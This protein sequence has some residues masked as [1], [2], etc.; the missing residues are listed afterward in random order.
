MSQFRSRLPHL[1]VRG[2]AEAEEYTSPRQTPR[3]KFPERSRAE[4]ATHL[5]GQIRD[6][7]K[8]NLQKRNALPLGAPAPDGIYLEFEGKAGFDL[9]IESLDL[10]SQGIELLSVK[11]VKDGEE[12][13]TL[14]SV[15]VPNEK[16]S[17]F[18]KKI[19]QYRDEEVKTKSKS[20]K[21]SPKNSP[22]VNSIENV[23]LAV[24]RSLWTDLDEVFPT[25][26]ELIWWEVWLRATPE[27]I[28][29][30]TNFA[31][32]RDIT[33]GSRHLI[34]PDRHV[35]LANATTQ[36]LSLLIDSLGFIAELRRAKETT[37]DFL[38]MPN[39]E[40]RQWVE[41]LKGIVNA[42]DP[43]LSPV[44][45]ILDTG[46]NRQHPLIE[47]FLPPQKLLT[48][49][50]AW[51][52]NDHHG[53]GT[54][55]TGVALYGDLNSALLS[56]VRI[57]IPCEVE[58]VKIV[59][60]TQP[61][62]PDLYGNVTEEAVNRAAVV[63]PNRRRIVC[64][65]ITSTDSRDRGQPSSWSAAVDNICAGTSVR[66][67]RH[68]F[69]ISAGNTDV[70]SRV[71]YPSSNLTDQ[72]HDPGQSWN[73]LTVGAFTE[74]TDITEVDYKGW[75]PL[76]EA[77]DIAPATTTSTTWKKKW[78]HKPDVVFEGGNAAI[79]KNQT[80]VEYP[81]SLLLLTTHGQALGPLFTWTSDT[82]AAA[83]QAA[84]LAAILSSEYP[85]FWAET[86]RALLVHS[87]EWTPRM[88]NAYPL[89]T[90][91]DRENLLRICGYG[92]PNLER[93]R[94]SASNNL[95]LIAQDELRPFDG[96][97]MKH[98]NI[99]NIPWPT[100]ELRAL[101]DTQ[102]R[103]KVTLS[104]FIEPNP[105][106]RGWEHKFRYQSHGLRFD[107]RTPTESAKEF[108]TR[109]NRKRW[110]EEL[111]RKTVTTSGD[112]TDWYFGEHIR[113]RGSIHNDVWEG[114]A[115]SL[116]ERSQLSVF[117]VVGWW[118][119]KHSEGHTTK[120]ARYSLIV[121]ISTPSTE[122]DLYTPVEAKVVTPIE[123]M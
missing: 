82:S 121:S 54:E 102:V 97:S 58:S 22:L 111:G 56:T 105:A 74:K 1:I 30:F 14:A 40:Q 89:K 42:P 2:S 45:C 85:D 6:S 92:V 122:I 64:M 90:K 78:P 83:A 88:K 46:V 93:A 26:D 113:S 8:S 107:V 63:D 32:A 98:L 25:E 91:N 3:P 23:R 86:L 38:R 115:V 17:A 36:Q 87:A 112:S 104:Y 44:V 119:E 65:A 39:S 9:K 52:A 100:E 11:E 43:K 84:N 16:I 67:K 35:V 77:G 28:P 19:E 94:W 96:N 18:I 27:A 59:H 49:N 33:I 15:F 31:Q 51:N 118:R 109:L 76:A 79:D 81:N 53:H 57:S 10:P 5:L 7:E 106:R 68:L 123:R 70:S 95:T 24:I 99:H 21:A 101:G 62:H 60:P 72:I 73:A 12:M 66:E 116:A 117:P 37:A 13:K 4:H 69:I 71:H 80:K 61:N 50:K 110:D 29:R 48:C 20:K 55:M 75:T 108:I 114:S 41:A 103:M 47:D 34:F 120:K